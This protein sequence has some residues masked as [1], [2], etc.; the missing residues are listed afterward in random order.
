MTEIWPDSCKNARGKLFE[1]D[2]CACLLA[3][4]CMYDG[5]STLS[6]KVFQVS[7]IRKSTDLSTVEGIVSRALPRANIL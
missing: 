5:G 7:F 4:V 1:F 3:C 2:V 6:K